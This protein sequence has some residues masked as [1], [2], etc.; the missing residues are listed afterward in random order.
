MS[1]EEN[2]KDSDVLRTISIL[3]GTLF[4]FFLAMVILARTIVY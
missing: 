3:M 2:V 4:G 1:S